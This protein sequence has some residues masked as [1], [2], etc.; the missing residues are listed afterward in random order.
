MKQI[1]LLILLSFVLLVGCG[2][3][4]KDNNKVVQHKKQ[5]YK[6]YVDSIN[7]ELDSLT[8]EGCYILV[9]GSDRNYDTIID[10]V[11]YI[12]TTDE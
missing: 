10:H 2:E 8:A 11:H 6:E 7:R 3:S 12:Y 5:S 1:I 9:R 4:K